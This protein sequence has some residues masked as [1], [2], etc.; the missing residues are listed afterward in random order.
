MGLI[1]K[2]KIA[3]LKKGY[4]TVS[5]KYNVQGG[6]YEGADPLYFGD[7]VAFGS[8][9]GHYVKLEDNTVAN[10]AGICLATNVKL[11]NKYPGDTENVETVQGEAFNLLVRGFVAVAVADSEDLTTAKA[12]PE[13]TAEEKK[14]KKEAIDAAIADMIDA[15]NE[16][17]PVYVNAN[18]EFD[19]AGTAL[20]GAYFMGVAEAKN[21]TVLAEINYRM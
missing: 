17:A 21:L 6:I 9:T 1:I 10:I 3:Q 14:A 12:M 19:T 15:I 16:G 11:V 18:G 4:P 8:A 20:P 13:T 2:N 7:L 5:D